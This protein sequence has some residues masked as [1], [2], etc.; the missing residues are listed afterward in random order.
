MGIKLP[1]TGLDNLNHTVLNE[2]AC[3]PEPRADG[4]EPQTRSSRHANAC[5]TAPAFERS[6][7]FVRDDSVF[8]AR[9]ARSLRATCARCR[10]GNRLCFPARGSSAPEF[11]ARAARRVEQER[12]ARH[13]R[14]TRS[15]APIRE[16]VRFRC[17]ATLSCSTSKANPFSNRRG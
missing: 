8:Y 17:R 9:G 3:H 5:V 11:H 1:A 6:V 15:P 2:T 16:W 12:V 13:R 7:T 14:R 10:A 4:E